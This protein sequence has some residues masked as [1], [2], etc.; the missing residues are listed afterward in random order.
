MWQ[1]QF[2]LNSENSIRNDLLTYFS[3]FSYVYPK[4]FTSNV[5]KYVLQPSI[6][7]AE[8]KFQSVYGVVRGSQ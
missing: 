1:I 2:S 3:L 6:D 7:N 8:S 4:L 5:Y